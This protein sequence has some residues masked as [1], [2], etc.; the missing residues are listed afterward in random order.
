MLMP[1]WRFVIHLSSSQAP[2]GL[3]VLVHI[4]DISIERKPP[5]RPPTP[6]G[7]LSQVH[8]KAPFALLAT[9]ARWP[10]RWPKRKALLP[11]PNSAGPHWRGANR[12]ALV[13]S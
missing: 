1:L 10:A 6:F 11:W 8:S 4:C 3:L 13:L 7:T 5:R 2:S 9:V 12:P